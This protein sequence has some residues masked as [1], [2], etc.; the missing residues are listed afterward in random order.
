[1]SDE[2]GAG[3]PDGMK[4]D[5]EGNIWCTGPGGVWVIATDGTHLGTIDCDGRRVTNFCFGGPDLTTLFITTFTEFGRLEVGV[6]G[7]CPP[8]T[9]PPTWVG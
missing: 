7:L 3:N 2:P 6:A 1:M 8:G 4:L 5:C 9:L